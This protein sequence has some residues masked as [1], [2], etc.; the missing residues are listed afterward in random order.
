MM[1]QTW[2]PLMEKTCRSCKFCTELIVKKVY[3]HLCG[4]EATLYAYG[5]KIKIRPN[6]LDIKHNCPHWKEKEDDNE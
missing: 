6:K 5:R 1:K 3:Q 2:L 4:S